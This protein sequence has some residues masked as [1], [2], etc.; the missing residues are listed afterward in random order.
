[1]NQKDLTKGAVYPTMCLFA[2]PM[3]VGNI[4]QQGYNV[5]DTWVVGH[6]AGCIGGGR[7]G[8]CINDFF[9]LGASG[10][11]YGQRRCIFSLFRQA[12]C[13]GTAGEHLCVFFSAVCDCGNSYGGIAAWGRRTDPV[14]EY[15]A[16]D[17]NDDKRLYGSY[18][19]RD[20]RGCRI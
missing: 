20:S 18:I 5:V 10:A 15:S 2:L 3:I 19:L 12:G 13:I 1:M 17:S 9:D 4:L 14:D 8:V 11:L 16:R 6:Y 7:F